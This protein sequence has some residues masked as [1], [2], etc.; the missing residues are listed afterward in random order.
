[1]QGR[2]SRAIISGFV[3]LV[4]IVFK[5]EAQDVESLVK[6]LGDKQASVRYEAV[7]ELVA[8][9]ESPHTLATRVLQ[10]LVGFA[11]TWGLPAAIY[12]LI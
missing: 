9:S 2:T 6:K 8:N 11:A 5:S 1:M 4:M 12:G 3:I 7:D 10:I